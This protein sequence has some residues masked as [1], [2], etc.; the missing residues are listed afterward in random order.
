MTHILITLKG[1]VLKAK[2]NR[3]SSNGDTI[4][5]MLP[6]ESKIN[7]WGDEIYFPL[8]VHLNLNSPVEVVSIGDIAYSRVYD[9]FCIF[10]GKTPIS[11]NNQ[12]IPNSPV[13]LIGRL[14]ENPYILKKLLSSP[15]RNRKR[16]ILNRIGFLKR[17]AET[18]RID[19][20]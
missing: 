19:R 13:D 17:Y 6:I 18:I 15:F 12:I 5:K 3:N 16:R 11:D 7:T 4:Y 20:R 9:A 1:R 10:Y 8:H 14:D 2:L